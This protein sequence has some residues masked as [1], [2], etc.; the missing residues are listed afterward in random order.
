MV[1]QGP[2]T[3][4]P[5]IELAILGLL[6]EA[7][8]HGYELRKKLTTTL[9]TFRAFS[10][11]SLYPTLRRLRAKGT[12]TEEAPPVDLDAVPLTSRRSRVVYRTDRGR[13]GTAGRAAGRRRAAVLV[14]R[15]LRRAPGVLLADHGR[16]PAAHPGGPAP[17]GRGA[18][19]GPAPAVE[20]AADRLDRYTQELQQLG[21]EATERE[22]RWLNELIAHEQAGHGA[23]AP[24][25]P[26][27]PLAVRRP[28]P[29]T[30]LADRSPDRR[31]A[32]IAAPRRPS[33][34]TPEEENHMGSHPI[35]VAIV[36]VGNCA[37]SLVQGVEYYRDADPASPGAR[38]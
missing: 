20:P 28:A 3:N 7:P 19:G 6:S 10:F 5:S 16:G 18:P 1:D 30:H 34:P 33:P 14:R 27:P 9:G 29:P 23:P 2:A 36:G 25:A 32:R 21:L 35:R 13:Q 4:A 31:T 12:I 17:P 11:G 24:A 22:V 15:R 26:R 38:A 37:S 8:M